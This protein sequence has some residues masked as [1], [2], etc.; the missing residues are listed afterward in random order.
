VHG[1][2]LGLS[3]REDAIAEWQA[4]FEIFNTVASTASKI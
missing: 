2:L 1:D 4:T 3:T